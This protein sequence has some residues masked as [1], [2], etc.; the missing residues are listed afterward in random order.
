[1]AAKLHV[2]QPRNWDSTSDTERYCSICY[3][4][5]INSV[6]MQPPNQRVSRA[7]SPGDKMDEEEVDHSPPFSK[8]LR[9]CGTTLPLHMR[10]HGVLLNYVQEQLYLYL[11][12]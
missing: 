7:L 9:K 3:W 11:S 1:M 5:E 6:S 10:L 12:K 2:V 8:R 4:A